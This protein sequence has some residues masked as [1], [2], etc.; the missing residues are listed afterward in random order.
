MDTRLAFLPV[1]LIPLLFV[2]ACSGEQSA[3]NSEPETREEVI[4]RYEGG[5]KRVVAVY[6]GTGKE[7]TLVKRI[8]YASSGQRIKVENLA[9]DTTLTFGDLQSQYAKG[10]SLQAYLT[11]TAWINA[12]NEVDGESSTGVDIYTADSLY[13]VIQIGGFSRRI[14]YSVDY[15]DG[16]R[17][18]RDPGGDDEPTTTRIHLRGPGEINYGDKDDKE[19]IYR[20]VKLDEMESVILRKAVRELQ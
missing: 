6:E 19:S 16:F 15:L 5:E 10:D 9:K 18:R 20:R 12:G 11:R 13:K 8:T 3:E 2:I 7:E 17:V 14:S 4:E 1:L